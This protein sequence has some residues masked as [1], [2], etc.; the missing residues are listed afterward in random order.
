MSNPQKNPTQLMNKVITVLCVIFVISLPFFY[1]QNKAAKEEAA[2]RATAVVTPTPTPTQTPTATPGSTTVP[3]ITKTIVPTQTPEPTA[4]PTPTQT[5]VPTEVPTTASSLKLSETPTPA[6]VTALANTP[7]ATPTKTPETTTAPTAE[8][9]QEPTAEPTQVPTAEPTQVPTAE[10]T[11]VPTAEPTQVPTA[12]PTQVPT[13]EPTQ[14]PTAEPTQVPTAEPTLAPTPTPVPDPIT[15]N[16]VKGS[17][18]KKKLA[19]YSAPDKKAWRGANNKAVV[20]PD[21]VEYVAG[22]YKSWTLIL[23][24]V[25]DGGYRVGY[26]NYKS[27]NDVPTLNFASLPAMINAPCALTD[28]PV[29]YS[30]VIANLDRGTEVTYLAT[31]EN[32]AYIETKVN[33]KVVRGFVPRENLA[34]AIGNLIRPSRVS[35]SA[36]LSQKKDPDAYTP[37]KAVDGDAKTSWQ[38]CLTEIGDITDAYFDYY[39]PSP[40]SVTTLQIKNGFWR[41]TNG[42]DQYGRNS[43]VKTFEITF[44][45]AGSETFTDPMTVTLPETEN[46]SKRKI[47]VLVDINAHHQVDA[48][49]L[50]MIDRY[51]GTNFPQDVCVSEIEVYGQ[52]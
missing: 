34:V 43:R 42:H 32:L 48:I 8:P 22:K 33:K 3:E 37:Q 46:W 6:I 7:T 23:Y 5:P 11:Q 16:F 31:Y 35:A 27:G 29:Q 51:I 45:Y 47:G 52:N 50:R 17:I 10:P 36:W 12:E 13:A 44:R 40:A 14:V 25:S 30:S 19:V 41:T 18:G 26:V 9:T 2:A 24:P 49:R 38:V 21:G 1:F 28:D 4:I 39:L 15:L 20:V